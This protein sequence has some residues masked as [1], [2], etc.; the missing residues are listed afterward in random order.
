MNRNN[1]TLWILA[2]SMLATGVGLAQGVFP[3]TLQG[4]L[5]KAITFQ[6]MPARVVAVGAENVELLSVLGVKP[7]GF[8]LLKAEYALGKKPSA[9]VAIL[10]SEVL[11]DAVYVGQ[12]R[13]P[14]TESIVNLKPDLVLTYGSVS[15]PE[16]H[17]VLSGLVP[18]LAY[19][20]DTDHTWREPLKDM[21]RLFRKE[22]E[23]NRF[24][25]RYD[26]KVSQL[27][28]KIA[29]VIRKQ[30]KTTFLYL[31]NASSVMLLG[32]KFSF[33][34]AATALGMTIDTPGGV[35]P[36]MMALPITPEAL[37]THKHQRI[38]ALTLDGAQ[39]NA[40]ANVAFEQLRKRGVPLLFYKMPPN[41]PYS[42]PLTDLKRLE[43]LAALI[44]K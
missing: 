43:D 8:A 36:D 20:F 21:G 34:K 25:T 35:N 40:A 4:D 9:P 41:Q 39:N 5:G 31:P 13:Q 29:P 28:V 2:G 44:K 16:P 38:V 12:S 15:S 14:S 22:T 37:L 17:H 10:G 24:L 42:G 6:K 11:P 26:Q 23:V 7:V 1:I 27:K 18:T 30:P 33:G 32:N 3:L 19:D